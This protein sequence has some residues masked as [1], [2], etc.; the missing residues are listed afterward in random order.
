M[1]FLEGSSLAGFGSSFGFGG[2]ACAGAGTVII[3]LHLGQRI[4]FPGVM[5]AGNLRF[6]PHFSHFTLVAFDITTSLDIQFR[7]Q[8]VYPANPAF[9]IG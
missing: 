8:T 7:W 4:F 6:A 9:A 2:A 3:S 1:G 5:V